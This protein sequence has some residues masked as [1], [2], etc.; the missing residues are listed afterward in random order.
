M[1][2]VPILGIGATRASPLESKVGSRMLACKK[3]RQKLD[4]GVAQQSFIEMETTLLA[5]R[6]PI[7]AHRQA[8]KKGPLC[9]PCLAGWQD[10]YQADSRP[11]TAILDT[12]STA[13]K[14]LDEA[15][16]ALAASAGSQSP[17]SP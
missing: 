10:E 7:Q 17:A 6:S 1:D 5:R 11:K 13:I 8:M 15:C 3:C 14:R 9:D 16:L 12:R 2:C 4:E